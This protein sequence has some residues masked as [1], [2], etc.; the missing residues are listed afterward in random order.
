M[1]GVAAFALFFSTLT[2]SPLGAT[3]GALAVL[4][5]SSLLFTLDAA[6]ADRAV[7]ADPVLAGVRR[8]LPRPDPVAGHRPRPGAAGRLRRR[9]AGRRLGELHHQGRHRA[10]CPRR[11][12]PRRRRTG[13]RRPAR[14]R[15]AR[16]CRGAN[17]LASAAA[18]S[19]PSCSSSEARSLAQAGLREAR[20]SAAASAWASASARPAGDHPVD[21]PDL[22]RLGGVDRAAG[23]DQVHRP[24]R[25]DQ[26]G[27]P[28]RA[29]V[30]QRHAPAAAEHPE[31]GVSS[32]TRRSHQSASSR[33]AGHGVPGDRGDHRLAQP[34][35]GRAHRPVAVG[36]GAVAGRRADGARGR[37][38]RRRCRPRRAARRPTASGSAS[39]ARKASAS[40]VAVAPS[41][42]L[43]ACGRDSR[44]VVTGP[45]R[46][47][48]DRLHSAGRYWLSRSAAAQ[49][50]GPER[51]PGPRR[52][53]SASTICCTSGSR[54][55]SPWP[56]LRAG[57]HR[58]HG[59]VQRAGQPGGVRR[60]DGLVLRR[61]DR[62]PGRA[63]PAS[64]PRR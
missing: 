6:V 29:A 38:R 25:A 33:P 2:D 8:L 43:R 19:R 56:D 48:R 37:R 15:P 45:S 32:A 61:P 20:R 44:T 35:P 59:Q 3:L 64:R 9:A 30:D 53:S 10:R 17:S 54:G 13:R 18:S 16:S 55:R 27:Q 50:S 46:S 24:A 36:L 41:T 26:P 21:Q 1:L 34:Q 47:T 22:Q 51:R 49:S 52:A 4:V 60:G 23:E 57:A 11:A 39:K 58:L 28:D 14:R 12:G 62:D 42:A 5:A 7:P 40:A 31:D 63:R